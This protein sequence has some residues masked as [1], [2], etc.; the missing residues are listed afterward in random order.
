MSR[1]ILFDGCV[2]LSNEEVGGVEADCASEQ[3]EAD[4][5]HHRVAKVQQHRHKRHNLQLREGGVAHE[6]FISHST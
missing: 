3:P 2:D 4:H 5:H 1:S 6:L